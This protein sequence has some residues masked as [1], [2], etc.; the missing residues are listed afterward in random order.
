M[1]RILVPLWQKLVNYGPWNKF[2]IQYKSWFRRLLVQDS[3]VEGRA[4]ICP[5]ESSNTATSCWTA[6]SRRML[7]P[8]KKDTPRPKTKKKLHQDGRR[9]AIMIISNPIPTGWVTHRLENNDAQRSSLTTVKV[10][11]LTS[12]F[13]AWRSD[14]GTG[15]PQGVCP[16]GSV[17][18]DYRTPRGLRETD[19]PVLE[20]TIRFCTH[21][22]PEER[23][24]NHTGC[25]CSCCC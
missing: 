16:W 15:N 19:S 10:L 2:R 21:Q 24:S 13:P 3:G 5:C 17:G 23:S 9:G 18:F 7:E 11:N 8:T 4:L 14:K 22:N 12:G 20:V 25:C 1:S 6:I